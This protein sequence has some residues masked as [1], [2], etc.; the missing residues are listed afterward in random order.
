MILEY[1]YSLFLLLFFGSSIFRSLS[2]SSATFPLLSLHAA[3]ERKKK[4]EERKKK[5]KE[6]KKE[7][8]KEGEKNLNS[9]SL[10]NIYVYYMFVMAYCI[11]FKTLKR[12]CW[13]AFEIV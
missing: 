9:L 2:A 13:N 11:Y 1:R 7:R 8:K 12:K 10:Y 3:A 4:E 6:R 5:E